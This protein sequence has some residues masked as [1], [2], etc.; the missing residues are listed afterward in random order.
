VDPNPADLDYP[1]I[2]LYGHLGERLQK[3]TDQSLQQDKTRIPSDSN[4]HDAVCL[5]WWKTCYIGKIQI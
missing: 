5:G 3:L 1:Q 2:P 4:D